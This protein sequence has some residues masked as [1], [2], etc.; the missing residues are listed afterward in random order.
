MVVR[1][2]R[3]GRRRLSEAC[4][5]AVAG[6]I[7]IEVRT[8]ATLTVTKPWLLDWPSLTVTVKT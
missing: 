7:E 2:G 4:A 5:V 6:E 3:E 8:C 1:R